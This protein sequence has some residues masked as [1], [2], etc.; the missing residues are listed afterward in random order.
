MSKAWRGWMVM[1]GLAVGLA[2]CG[3]AGV[4]SPTP[5]SPTAGV[6]LVASPTLPAPTLAATEVATMSGAENSPTPLP[7]GVIVSTSVPGG[8]VVGPPLTSIPPVVGQ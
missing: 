8:P 3:E 1:V 5:L 6:G 7:N 2:G 4:A